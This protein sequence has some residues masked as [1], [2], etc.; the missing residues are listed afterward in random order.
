[1]EGL[2]EVGGGLANYYKSL[3][4]V[5]IRAAGVSA[6]IAAVSV[7]LVKM[8]HSSIE[9]GEKIY[10]LAQHMHISYDEASRL[11]KA[12]SLVGVDAGYAGTALMRLDKQ[13]LNAGTSGNA[14]SRMLSAFGVS[15]RNG[16]GTLKDY[17][18]QLRALADGYQRAKKL[19]WKKSTSLK[20]LVQEA[21]R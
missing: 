8:S 5:A 17:N 6:A 15:L 10:K 3:A 12:F 19:A 20:S 1:M 11:N 7:A 13:V 4:G 2:K 16:D 9:A 14:A 21:V 18:Q